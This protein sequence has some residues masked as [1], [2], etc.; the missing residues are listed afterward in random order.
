MLEAGRRPA[1]GLERRRSTRVRRRCG[2]PR[3]AGR[4]GSQRVPGG[5]RRH[6]PRSM[7]V[8]P[9]GSARPRRA[10]VGR[11]VAAF[12][13]SP[14]GRALGLV[15]LYGVAAVVATADAL[16]SFRSAFIAGGAP[17]LGEPGAGDHLQ[18][19]YRFWLVGHQLG[20][21]AAPWRDPYSFQPLVE[22]QLNLAGLALRAAVLAARGCVRPRGG[23]EH[24]A[25]HVC[26][27]RRA[28]DV[29]LA[30]PPEAAACRGH[31]RRARFRDRALPPGPERR[32]PARLD[33]RA[34]PRRSLCLRAL[35]GSLL[36]EGR[37]RVGLRRLCG[38]RLAAAFGTGAPRGRC[39]AVLPRLCDRAP[40]PGRARLD[41]RRVRGRKR[42]GDR[43]PRDRDRRLPGLGRPHD[44][45]GRDVPGG[46]AGSPQP[47]PAR[48]SRGVRL[49]GLAHADRRGGRPGRALAAPP[50][51]RRSCSDWPQS[52]RSSSR[53]ARTRRSTSPSGAGFRPS[54]SPAFPAG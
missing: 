48:R 42:R 43:P 3:N 47:L 13:A 53:S 19:V 39:V 14:A 36:A 29:R 10:A 8:R 37:A 15:A 34:P 26:R 7:A 18:T 35:A 40:Q 22:P 16:G 2:V 25:A 51:A 11:T 5:P 21:G 38:P 27:D 4:S 32:P 30:A 1:L 45:P 46:L 20:D 17:G 31:A 28:R 9:L 23:V 33:R 41:R 54:I 12:V 44:R 49:R 52:Y 6:H 50:L 24:A